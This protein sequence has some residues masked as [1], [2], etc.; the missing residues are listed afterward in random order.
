MPLKSILNTIPGSKVSPCF[1]GPESDF[2]GVYHCKSTEKIPAL[3][4]DQREF[5]CL[6][7]LQSQNK[8][9]QDTRKPQTPPN[10]K[11]CISLC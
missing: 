1:A 2:R 8:T 9:K 4:L 10:N 5:Y 6:L 3:H 11:L 7:V